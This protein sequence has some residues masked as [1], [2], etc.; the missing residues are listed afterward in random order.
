M[1]IDM[2]LKTWPRSLRAGVALVVM[3]V[4]LQQAFV[5]LQGLLLPDQGS[6]LVVIKFVVAL[7]VGVTATIAFYYFQSV[8][9]RSA[10]PHEVEILHKY[11]QS[12]PHDRYKGTATPVFS[13][14]QGELKPDDKKANNSQ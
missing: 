10:K 1:L 8:D 14:H 9:D 13:S 5:G 4:S 6:S 12:Q 2:I 11:Q 3:I 7:I